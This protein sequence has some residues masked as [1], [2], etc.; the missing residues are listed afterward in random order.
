MDV[1]AIAHTASPFHIDADD[2][3][4]VIVPAI[5]G[6]KNLLAAAKQYGNDVKR[7]VLTSSCTAIATS[8]G[9]AGVRD[10]TDWNEWSVEEVRTKGRDAHPLDKYR[11]SKTLSE[12]AAWD[13]YDANKAGLRWDMVVLN[14]SFVLG[15]WLHKAEN[16]SELSPSLRYYH[17][18]VLKAQE[19]DEV[20]ATT[21]YVGWCSPVSRELSIELWA[22]G[23]LGWMSVTL[24]RRM[25][26]RSSNRQPVANVL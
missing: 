25:R 5:L 16:M 13:W 7:V 12:R 21:G 2:P 6:T 22:K 11:A 4:E 23:R 9:E 3:D 15:P 1:D 20:L 17:S 26:S 8:T 24:P 14:P 10:E 18:M 19:S